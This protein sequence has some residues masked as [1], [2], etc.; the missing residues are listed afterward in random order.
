MTRKFLILVTLIAIAA[1]AVAL[2]GLAP[3]PFTNESLDVSHPLTTTVDQEP[4]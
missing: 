1:I 2:Y 4:N 3:R